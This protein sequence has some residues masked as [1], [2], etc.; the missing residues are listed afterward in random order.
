MPGTDLCIKIGWLDSVP[1]LPMAPTANMTW[2][3]FNADQIQPRHEQ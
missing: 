2:G 1:K 3:P